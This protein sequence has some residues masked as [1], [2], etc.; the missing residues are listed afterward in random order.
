MHQFLEF[1]S[2][3]DPQHLRLQVEVGGL[4]GGY[5]RVHACRRPTGDAPEFL[6]IARVLGADERGIL[7]IAPSMN[8]LNL[9]ATLGGIRHAKDGGKFLAIYLNHSGLMDRFAQESLGVSFAFRE[10]PEVSAVEELV[11]YQIAFG[12]YPPLNESC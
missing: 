5:Y 3:A 8:F 12:E 1:S 6:P 2:L 7:Y 4:A 10:N 9:C 11:R